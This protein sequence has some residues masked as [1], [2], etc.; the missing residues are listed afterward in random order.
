MLSPF[1]HYFML[2]FPFVLFSRF[3]FQAKFPFALNSRFDFKLNSLLGKFPVLALNSLLGVFPV[4]AFKF[5]FLL[6]G[7]L[8]GQNSRFSF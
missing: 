7:P 3:E 6:L 4:L 8:G 1:L 5:P 2:K